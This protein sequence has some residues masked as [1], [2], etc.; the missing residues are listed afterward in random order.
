[1]FPEPIINTHVIDFSYYF[2]LFFPTLFCWI[3]AVFIVYGLKFI[4]SEISLP[5]E[6][7]GSAAADVA[8]YLSA[9]SSYSHFFGR[10]SYCFHWHH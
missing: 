8:A 4:N 1:M 9:G 5:Q 10:A 2:F 3:L 7:I 6:L